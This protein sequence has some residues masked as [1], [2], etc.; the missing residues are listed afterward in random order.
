MMIEVLTFMP[1]QVTSTRPVPGLVPLPIVHVHDTLPLVSVVFGTSP[2][3]AL[4]VPA[5]VK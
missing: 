5:G 3:A 2:C 4:F 1:A